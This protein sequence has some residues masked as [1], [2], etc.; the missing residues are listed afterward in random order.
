M[1][2]G[3][4]VCVG[5]TDLVH[6][7]VFLVE[8]VGRFDPGG[9]LFSVALAEVI[10]RGCRC[11]GVGK[12]DRRWVLVKIGG[13]FEGG[14]LLCPCCALRGGFLSRSGCRG[15]LHFGKPTLEIIDLGTPF[16]ES[17]SGQS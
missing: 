9:N 12:G 17:A 16:P 11:L 13:C 14:L 15:T 5:T 3:L 1:G 4:G 7:A 6:E 2:G 8:V 10:S